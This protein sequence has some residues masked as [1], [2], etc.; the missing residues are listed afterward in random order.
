MKLSKIAKAVIA[1][2]VL[3]GATAAQ[4]GV[5]GSLGFTSDYMLRGYSQTSE[6]PAIQ[7]GLT[8]SHDSG[9]FIGAWGSNVAYYIDKP[10][11]T[12]QNDRYVNGALEFDITAGYGGKAGDLG[13]EVGMIAYN[14]PGYN[15]KEGT[16]FNFREGYFKLMYAGFTFGMN[17]STNYFAESGKY[18]WTYLDYS[19]DLGAVVVNAHIGHNQFESWEKS[20]LAA[21][22]ASTQADDK[23]AYNDYK[24]GVA[25]TVEG[26]TLDLSYVGSD[27]KKEVCV[28]AGFACDGRA[29]FTVSKSF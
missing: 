16:T 9:A 1:G 24:L 5:T 15:P 28:D 10:G 25:K 27:T 18:T 22:P 26:V 6:S 12:T 17:H 7:G 2:S 3:M 14:Y 21:F 29:V 13:Y 20:A 19:K 8:Y 4:A 11:A 23:K